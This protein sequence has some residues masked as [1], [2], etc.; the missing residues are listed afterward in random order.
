MMHNTPNIQHARKFREWMGEVE[1]TLDGIVGCGVDDL[2]DWDYY[3]A[4]DEGWSPEDAALSALDAAG[5]KDD[6]S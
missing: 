3:E 5:F 6:E 2:P 4:F 1:A